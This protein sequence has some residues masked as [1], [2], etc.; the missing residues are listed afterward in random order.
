MRLFRRAGARFS[1]DVVHERILLPD[2][3]R[4]GRLDGRLLH[5]S[6]RDLGHHLAKVADYAWLGARRRHARGRRGAGLS[7][8]LL[9]GLWTFCWVYFVRLGLLDGRAG[10]LVAALYGQTTF[11]TYAA[12]WSLR[13]QPPAGGD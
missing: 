3:A 10:F 2:G 7:G 6:H 11:N 1:D 8:A 13:R 5:Y 9:R 12:L 4:I